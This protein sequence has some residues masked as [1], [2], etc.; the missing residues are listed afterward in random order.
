[1]A[2]THF[3]VDLVSVTEGIETRRR[4]DSAVLWFLLEHKKDNLK[5]AH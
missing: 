2:S 4:L 1:M 3:A 5:P